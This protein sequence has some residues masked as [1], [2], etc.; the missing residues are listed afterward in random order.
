MLVEKGLVTPDQCEVAVKLQRERGC[1]FGEAIV[2]L[3]FVDDETIAEC[4]AAQYML[5]T[6]DPTAIEVRPEALALISGAQALGRLMLPFAVDEYEI[7]VAV[8]D[9]LD[10]TMSDDLRARQKKPIRQYVGTVNKLR[11]AIAMHYKLPVLVAPKTAPK[12]PRKPR[13][14]EQLDR[15]ALLAALNGEAA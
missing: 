14:E 13:I 12:R 10:L 1:R 8:A 4:L 9:P 11:T 6:I 5:S 15:E 3:G 7:K 2:D